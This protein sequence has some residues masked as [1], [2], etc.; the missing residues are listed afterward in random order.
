MNAEL[1]GRPG[2]A[3]TPRVALLG[4]DELTP[5]Q[6][7]LHAEIIGGPRRTQTSQVPLADP[8]GRLLGPFGLMLLHTRLGSVVQELGATLRFDGTFTDRERELAILTVAAHHASEFEWVA[9]ENAAHAAG[10]TIAQLQQLL[11]GDLPAGLTPTEETIV[12]T[13]RRLVVERGLDDE[14]YADSTNALGEEGLAALI[15]LVGYYE[16]LAIA[17]STFRPPLCVENRR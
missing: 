15:W 6:K 10:V 4:P 16:M 13:V 3:G 2:P 9:H 14:A 7:R 1:R 17:L 11:D 8:E 12:V 5:D